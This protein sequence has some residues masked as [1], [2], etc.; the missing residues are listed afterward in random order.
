MSV[1]IITDGWTE[2]TY[3]PAVFSDGTRG[4]SRSRGQ[5]AGR[6][7]SEIVGLGTVGRLQ[8]QTVLQR[9]LQRRRTVT[10]PETVL[11]AG[12]GFI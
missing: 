3:Y 7:G 11:W 2:L 12:D 9:P 6:E 5:G 1:T 4:F 8:G 10:P